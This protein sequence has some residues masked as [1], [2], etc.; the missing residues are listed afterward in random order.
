MIIYIIMTQHLFPLARHWILWSPGEA[1]LPV[2]GR[3]A[4]QYWFDNNSHTICQKKGRESQ[5]NWK[6]IASKLDT[7]IADRYTTQAQTCLPPMDSNIFSNW[8]RSCWMLLRRMQGCKS[9]RINIT[10]LYCVEQCTILCIRRTSNIILNV[11]DILQKWHIECPISLQ[12][13][14][15]YCNSLWAWV[16]PMQWK[17]HCN[18]WNG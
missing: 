1:V 14:I 10:R 12:L 16:W 8:T 5:L 15:L 18:T 9:T 2:E 7:D 13:L 6:W 17:K 4:M 3:R 11:V